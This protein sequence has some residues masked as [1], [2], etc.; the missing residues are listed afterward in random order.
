[1][2]LLPVGNAVLFPGGVMPLSLSSRDALEVSRV[3]RAQSMPI[4]IA[5][6]QATENAAFTG[7]IAILVKHE[8]G[9]D[10]THN[11]VVQGLA[12]ARFQ[13]QDAAGGSLAV[14][15]VP[16]REHAASGSRAAFHEVRRVAL[17]ILE[18][19]PEIPAS[20]QEL[21][22]GI[23]SPGHLADIVAANIDMPIEHRQAVLECL[24]AGKRQEM[25]LERMQEQLAVLKA[26]AGAAE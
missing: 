17:E 16:L 21:L 15:V 1:M 6:A 14:A 23:H 11:V 26:A 12:R 10:G 20:A 8:D 2:S 25:V 9:K 3:A 19:L 5:L 22:L 13:W 7:C 4:A 24:D 18:A